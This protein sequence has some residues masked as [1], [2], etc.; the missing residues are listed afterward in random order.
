MAREAYGR[1]SVRRDAG[2]RP[3]GR[4]EGDHGSNAAWVAI[5][6]PRFYREA[7]V[8][9]RR[10]G[11]GSST[12][13]SSW[14]SRRSCCARS[15]AGSARATAGAARDVRQRARAQPVACE[16]PALRQR[17][18]RRRPRLLRR[19]RRARWPPGRST[20][21]IPHRMTG[22]DWIWGLAAL[23]EAA[24]I[25]STCSAP[26]PGAAREAARRLRR[27]YPR[28]TIVGTHHGYFELDTPHNERVL[29][30]INARRPDILL[31]GMG[32]PEAGAVGRPLRRPPRRRRP[33]DRR[34]PVRLRLRPGAAR[35]P[36]ARR[37]RPGMDLPTRDR[38]ATDVAPLPAGEPGV[39]VAGRGRDAP[40]AGTAP[41]A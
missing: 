1:G 37:Q 32:T 8:T 16:C 27:W 10:S 23:C 9:A 5:D 6:E 17:A 30:D 38:T 22:A 40:P 20:L 2:D 35:P 39:P 25:R 14:A 28:L 7:S 34:R 11:R 24:G 15:P 26:S 13:R 33:V 4:A 21:E 12:S 18:R 19:L 3:A 29:E 36:L 41:P 31:V